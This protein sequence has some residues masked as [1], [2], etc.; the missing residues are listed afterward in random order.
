MIELIEDPLDLR[1]RVDAAHGTL[2]RTF[3]VHAQIPLTETMTHQTHGDHYDKAL[4]EG[5]RAAKVSLAD[6]FAR[7]QATSAKDFVVAQNNMVCC[8]EPLEWMTAST[9]QTRRR[10]RSAC[11]PF[12]FERTDVF[13]QGEMLHIYARLFVYASSS[14]GATN[15]DANQP[16]LSANETFIA[17]AQSLLVRLLL[18]D[19]TQLDDLMNHVATTVFQERLR[20]QLKQLNLVAFVAN[21]SILPRKSGASQAPMASPPA[22]PFCAPMDSSMSRTIQ[23]E[24]G[25]LAAFVNVNGQHSRRGLNATANN[26]TN[27]IHISGMG[28][29]RGITLIVGGGYH[30]KS[31]MLRC[32]A[33]GVYNKCFGDG[34]EFCVT[35]DDAVTIRAEDGRHVNNC[36]ISAFISNLPSPPGTSS[37]VDTTHFS[38]AEASGSTSQAASTVEAI[39]MGASAFLVDE[40]VSAA[41]FM[42]RD[43]RMRAMIMD[44]SIT[45]LLYRVN[46]LYAA[47]GIS[48][49]V[50]VGGVGDWLDVPD[51]VIL[52]DKYICKDATAKAKSVSKQFSHG[53]VQ[54]AGRGVVHRLEWNKSGT[55]NPRRPCA[56]SCTRYDPTHNS[57]S[58]VEG[59][60]AIRVHP[61]DDAVQIDNDE[62]DDDYIDMSRCEQLVGKKPQLY[63]TGMC[64]LQLIEICR[65]NPNYGLADFLTKLDDFLDEVGMSFCFGDYDRD[66]TRAALHTSGHWKLLVETMGC[67][68]RPRRFEVGQ[69][70][71]RL[72]GI[73]MVVLPVTED[74]AEIAERVDAER[75]KQELLDLWN[76][77][78]AHK[79]P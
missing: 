12:I 29:P 69:A 28:V 7:K 76:K 22:V 65:K 19:S 11:V 79:I 14:A 10:K 57:I 33:S 53:H 3:I 1:G 6:F 74:E 52:M 25:A 35:V 72:H 75:R 43:G 55:P 77:R 46:G 51:Q 45:P 5:G 54:Y 38:T 40:D 61:L 67:A 62:H 56:D 2:H 32:I 39:E 48:S 37:A 64:A 63:G 68:L 17:I 78:R 44:E 31:T 24:M 42:A 15:E 8:L 4:E 49:I 30:G 9:S 50:V 20:S 23:V 58:L 13:C 21:G 26:A 66:C 71:T 36:N 73:K 59:M 18:L 41:N 16:S 70:L 34:R 27:V 47:K 60:D